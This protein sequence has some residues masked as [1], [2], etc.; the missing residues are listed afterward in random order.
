MAFIYGVIA[1]SKWL[2]KDK[3][4]LGIYGAWPPALPADMLPPRTASE[5]I[6]IENAAL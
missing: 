2:G 6:R 5:A 4:P 1:A 3:F